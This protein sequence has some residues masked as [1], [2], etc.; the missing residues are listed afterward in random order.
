[1]KWIIGRSKLLGVT[2]IALLSVSVVG[3]FAVRAEQGHVWT[4]NFDADR[5]GDPPS[6]FSFGRTGEGRAGRWVVQADKSAPSGL[7]V[8]AQTDT[9]TTDYR[10]PIAVANEPLLHDVQLS[11][12]CKPVS[13]QVDQAAGLVFRYRDENN[14]Y[15][16]RA[17]ALEDNI[18]FYRVL[19]GR[20]QQFAGWNGRVTNGVWHELRVEAHGDHF[21]IYWD[22]QKVIDAHDKTFSEAGKVGVWTKADSVTEFDDL[23]V[24]PLGS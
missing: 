18:N 23:K 3:V 6:G 12:R 20:R 24:E 8:L 21:E 14:Y 1:M 16:T 15:V 13:G 2:V 11:V 9:D 5:P 17:N 4:W 7:N 19:N 22:G 10:F